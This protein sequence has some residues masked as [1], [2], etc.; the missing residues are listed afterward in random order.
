LVIAPSPITNVVVL[1][2]VKQPSSWRPRRPWLRFASLAVILTFAGCGKK[3]PP[4]APMVRIPA[5]VP[6]IQAHRVGSDAFITLTIP[7]TNI[8]RS[9]PVDIG[10]VEIYGYTG[11]RPP[12]RRDGL[13]SAT[14][15]R[16]S[17]SSLHR[18]RALL[19]MRRQLSILQGSVAGM[20]VTVIDRLTGQKLVQGKVEELPARGRRVPTQ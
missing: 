8:D 17:P 3:G 10:R 5:P 4:L 2:A 13:S 12:P 19:L 1:F 11:R 6:T 18:C 14:S 9:L 20:M 15:S 7:N 16:Q